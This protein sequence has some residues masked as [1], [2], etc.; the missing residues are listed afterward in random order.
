MIELQKIREV[1]KTKKFDKFKKAIKHQEEL[2]KEIKSLDFFKTSRRKKPTFGGRLFSFVLAAFYINFFVGL[3]VESNNQ[4]SNYHHINKNFE[5]YSQISNDIDKKNNLDIQS[6]Q[7]LK[8]MPTSTADLY[9]SVIV[10]KILYNEKFNEDT[11]KQI[12][13]V[14]SENYNFGTEQ[15]KKNNKCIISLVCYLKSSV[16]ER[17]YESIESS[18][19]KTAIFAKHPDIFKKHKELIDLQI[20]HQVHID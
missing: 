2:N 14:Y 6:Y 18:L 11:K 1:E 5:I 9:S 13:K 8:S 12:F 3:A 17:Y 16:T 4:N 10:T 20:K 7:K 19:N 15:E